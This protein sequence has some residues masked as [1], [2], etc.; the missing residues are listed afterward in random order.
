[1]QAGTSIIITTQ[2]GLKKTKHTQ[3]RSLGEVV[4][5]YLSVSKHILSSYWGGKGVLVKP[6]AFRVYGYLKYI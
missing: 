2:A 5:F 6:H 3:S 4:Y 1:M